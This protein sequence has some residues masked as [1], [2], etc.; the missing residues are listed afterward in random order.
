MKARIIV[1]AVLATVLAAAASTATGGTRGDAGS[2]TVWLQV[3]ARSGWSDVVANATKAFQAQHPGVQVN[4]EYQEWSTHLTKLDAAIAGN[5][6]PDVVELGNTEMTKYM[7]AGAFAPL[8]K[9][10]FPNSSTWLKGLEASA[11]FKGRLL[12]RPQNMM[13]AILTN[14][15]SVKAAATDASKQITEILN[16]A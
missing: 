7:G 6:A 11:T 1:V 16:E 9:S 8:T 2:I 4:V 15:K 13:T 14:K 5:N 3:D 10:V 12:R